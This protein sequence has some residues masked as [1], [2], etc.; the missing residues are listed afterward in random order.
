MGWGTRRRCREVD[1]VPLWGPS[2]PA[3]RSFVLPG[4]PVGILWCLVSRLSCPVL[5][6]GSAL[7]VC[8]ISQS[9]SLCASRTFS[10]ARDRRGQSHAPSSP[11]WRGAEAAGAPKVLITG[12]APRQT[13][14]SGR[15]GKLGQGRAP[16]TG[17][18]GGRQWAPNPP[19]DPARCWWARALVIPSQHLFRKCPKTTRS[20]QNRGR[21]AAPLGHGHRN[22]PAHL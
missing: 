13:T 9:I 2:L 7:P 11:C 3:A 15:D 17:W 18:F 12:T 22:S 6:H 1:A 8:S 19:S 10:W 21:G 4:L 5:D 14:T 20:H 16:I